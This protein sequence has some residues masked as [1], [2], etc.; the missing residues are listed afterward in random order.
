[1]AYLIEGLDQYQNYKMRMHIENDKTIY[2]YYRKLKIE[3]D[4][5]GS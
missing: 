3:D 4:T 5:H 1:M 2:I